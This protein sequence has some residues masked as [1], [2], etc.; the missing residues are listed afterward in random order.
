MFNTEKNLNDYKLFWQYPAITEKTFYNQ[1][2][3]NNQF[4]GFPWATIID[5]KYDYKIIYNLLKQYTKPGTEYYTC[6]QHISFRKLIPLWK[7]LNIKTVFISHKLLNEDS[8]NNILLK[9]CP[10]FAVNVETVNFSK[11]IFNKDL[12]N[13]E[14]KILYNF[15]G[16]YQPT[17]LT[18]IRLNIFKMD[19]PENT[20]IKFTG[21]WHFNK[22]VYHKKQNFNEELNLND[23]HNKKTKYYNEILLDSR[24]TLAPS[25]SGPNSIRFW[26]AL[27]AGS[28]PILL[29]DTLEL[30]EHKL[31]D[32]AIIKLN[33]NKIENLPTILNNISLKQEK[34]MRMNC[35]K[36]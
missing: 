30:P 1:N 5:K 3:Y 8:I 9:P 24:Y 14:R 29:S 33:E 35:L 17:Y 21:D 23:E 2:K 28:I 13:N 16:G 7:S 31:W 10:L 32:H 36:I 12:L 19:H 6:C 20:L 27:G 11:H 25:G 15:I 4:L 26:E 18:K 34:E 22:L